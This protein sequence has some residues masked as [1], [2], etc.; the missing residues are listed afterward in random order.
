MPCKVDPAVN[1][2]SDEVEDSLVNCGEGVVLVLL[3]RVSKVDGLME[4]VAGRE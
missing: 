4:R 2:A 1:V 3:Y